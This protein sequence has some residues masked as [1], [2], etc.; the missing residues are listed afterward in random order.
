MDGNTGT[1][2]ETKSNEYFSENCAGSEVLAMGIVRQS[3][4][5]NCIIL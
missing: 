2:D 4:Q 1:I 5:F 3:K